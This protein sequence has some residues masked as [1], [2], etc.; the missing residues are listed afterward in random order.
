MTQRDQLLG[1]RD[2]LAQ[3]GIAFSALI[4]RRAAPRFGEARRRAFGTTRL[5]AGIASTAEER[6][7]AAA[8][9]ES[10]YASRGYRVADLAHASESEFMLIADEDG[11]TVGT[12]TLR[13]DGP[14]GLR[15][16]ESYREHID[17]IR[18]VGKGVCELGRFAVASNARS[19]PVLAALFARAYELG[20]DLRDI[21]DVFIEVNPRHV[22]F[23]R[24]LFGFVVA[25]GGRMCPRVRAPSVL[26]RLEMAAFEDRL[27]DYATAFWPQR[28][29]IA[30]P[31]LN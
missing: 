30:S 15:A 10:R 14:E 27:R 29:L 17:A 12:L 24:K 31:A 20:R 8:L 22:E 26:L 6:R 2:R 7:A 13:L 25:A 23:Y 5:E 16:D 9:V 11:A 28:D 4:E 19:T 3:P 21:T 1:W 18:A